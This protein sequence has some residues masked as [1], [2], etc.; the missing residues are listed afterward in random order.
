MV[1]NNI[2][3]MTHGCQGVSASKTQS[4]YAIGI[5]KEDYWMCQLQKIFI[6]TQYIANASGDDEDDTYGGEV[7]PNDWLGLFFG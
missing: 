2:L 7:F 6:F 3:F 5:F 4:A 1:V